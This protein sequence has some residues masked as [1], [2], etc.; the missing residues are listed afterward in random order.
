MGIGDILELTTRK[1]MFYEWWGL[2]WWVI[3][4]LI[5]VIK[6]VVWFFVWRRVVARRRMR[7]ERQQQM[8]AG[9][10]YGQ[11]YNQQ[12]FSGIQVGVTGGDQYWGQQQQQVGAPF[13][14]PSGGWAQ[15]PAYGVQTGHQGGAAPPPYSQTQ[16][17]VPISKY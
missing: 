7:M 16:N 10:A 4:V 2:W 5:L 17:Y 14:Q 1:K 11:P 8:Q 15:P 6:A 3:V 13:Q 9:T 12:A